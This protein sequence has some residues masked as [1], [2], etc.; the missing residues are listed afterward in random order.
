MTCLDSTQV[1][2]SIDVVFIRRLVWILL[3]IILACLRSLA[4]SQRAWAFLYAQSSIAD[5][6]VKPGEQGRDKTS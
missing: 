5:V 3:R 1:E 4:L 6:F 2:A